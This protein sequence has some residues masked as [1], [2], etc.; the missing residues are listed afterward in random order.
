MYGIVYSTQLTPMPVP[1]QLLSYFG[2]PSWCLPM[3]GVIDATQSHSIND[4]VSEC[5]NHVDIVYPFHY[6]DDSVVEYFEK[7]T[8][9]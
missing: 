4:L 9:F 8:D 1:Y 6:K 2:Q 5:E 3:T 7:M